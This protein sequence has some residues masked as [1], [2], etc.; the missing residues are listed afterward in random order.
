MY[1]LVIPLSFCSQVLL[2]RTSLKSCLSSMYGV[3]EDRLNLSLVRA[4]NLSIGN[5]FSVCNTT[6]PTLHFPEVRW[7]SFEKFSF[8]L[9]VCCV[10]VF[11]CSCAVQC[12]CFC[13]G[14]F[15][16]VP[17]NMTCLHCLQHSFFEHL[18]NYIDKRL[19]TKFKRWYNSM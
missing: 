17:L 16:M 15:V 6:V 18:V 9:N 11:T 13:T 1:S 19:Q 12:V 4:A 8:F 5:D 14:L 2:D 7:Q 10:L 3:P